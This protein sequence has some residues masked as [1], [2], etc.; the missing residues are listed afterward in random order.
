VLSSAGKPPDR[1][2]FPNGQSELAGSAKAACAV[3]RITMIA[4][5]AFIQDFPF[6]FMFMVIWGWV[7]AI[8]FPGSGGASP[9]RPATLV[10]L[11]RRTVPLFHAWFC[12][13][14]ALRQE[15]PGPARG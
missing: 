4:T 12:A 13:I 7:P 1:A 9:F 15:L 5:H 11:G 3:T 14:G 8:F 6:D 2:G 10:F